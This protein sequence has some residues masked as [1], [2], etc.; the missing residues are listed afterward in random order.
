MHISNEYTSRIRPREEDSSK[1][2]LHE[3]LLARATRR[4]HS[5]MTTVL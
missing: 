1:K 3:G 4:N 2:S 5:E